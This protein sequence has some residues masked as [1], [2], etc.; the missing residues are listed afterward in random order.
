MNGTRQGCP[1]FRERE[2]KGKK[3]KKKKKKLSW[4]LISYFI[5]GNESRYLSRGG[6]T[7]PRVR[8]GDSDL[9]KWKTTEDA[10]KIAGNET[11][12]CEKGGSGG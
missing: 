9:W 4:Q 5:G 6:E 12:A 7:T 11:F 3:E 1:L 8:G 2:K 10:I